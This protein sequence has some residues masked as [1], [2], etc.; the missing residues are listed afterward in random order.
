[1]DEVTKKNIVAFYH[2]GDL[3]G[4]SSAAIICK[5][6]KN[7]NITLIGVEYGETIDEASYIKDVDV[8]YVVDYTFEPF[9]RMV[10]LNKNY[11]LIWVDHHKTSPQYVEK[12]GGKF[13][14]VLGDNTGISFSSISILSI[15]F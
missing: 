9:D 2:R 1:M 13:E 15:I 10:E 6:F 3:D 8:V 12:H 5:K 11:N 7:D 4:V 14:G